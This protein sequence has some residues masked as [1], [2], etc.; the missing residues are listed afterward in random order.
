LRI[1]CTLCRYRHNQHALRELQAVADAVPAGQ[2]CRAT[3][4]AEA[5]SAMQDLVREAIGQGR[6]AV[7][8]AALA[9]QVRL[10]RSAVLAGPARPPPAPAR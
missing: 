7:D 9:G 3:Q 1:R 8:P 5:L 2:W 10:L 6:D 4:A